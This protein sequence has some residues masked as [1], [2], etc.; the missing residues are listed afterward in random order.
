MPP[1][2]LSTTFVPPPGNFSVLASKQGESDQRQ[3]QVRNRFDSLAIFLFHT[4]D[5]LELATLQYSAF[6]DSLQEGKVHPS[7]VSIEICIQTT[8]ETTDRKIMESLNLHATSPTPKTRTT[9][10]PSP[11]TKIPPDRNAIVVDEA[12]QRYGM[13][14]LLNNTAVLLLDGDIIPIS[15]LSFSDLN[16]GE[17]PI[18]C[19][20]KIS[21]KFA[22]YY[23]WIGW[24]LLFPELDESLLKN[25]T[26][27]R[28]TNAD[29]GSGTKSVTDIV[30]LNWMRKTRIPP[31]VNFANGVF[32][33]DIQWL[34][35][36]KKENC[37]FGQ[38]LSIGDSH[39]FHMW[40]A[41][42]KYRFSEINERHKNMKESLEKIK[43]SPTIVIE[44][45]KEVISLNPE[46]LSHPYGSCNDKQCCKEKQKPF[47]L[48][49]NTDKQEDLISNI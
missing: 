10:F 24:I 20:S 5:S 35:E 37:Y 21:S 13:D 11:K 38:V 19:S 14:Y 26:V 45:I 32:D 40:S 48:H 25:F 29:T 23:C 6:V 22:Y 1:P 49:N 2:L 17:Y 8:S 7:N 18:T 3:P 9:I 44:D 47:F 15:P 41:A 27:T 12:F 30:G 16:L 39:F 28:R 36:R 34:A 42:S 46:L 43:N 33:N 4:P 31:G